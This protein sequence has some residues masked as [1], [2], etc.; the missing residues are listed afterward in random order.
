MLLRYCFSVLEQ[1][2]QQ[3]QEDHK[4]IKN[5][6][7]NKND[8]NIIPPATSSKEE[9]FL[10][11]STTI[12]HVNSSSS[13]NNNDNKSIV[14]NATSSSNN[15]EEEEEEEGSKEN[16]SSPLSAAAIAAAT[17]TT[18]TAHQLPTAILHIGPHKTGSSS[19]QTLTKRFMNELK[20]DNYEMPWAAVRKE[21]QTKSGPT[22]HLFLQSALCPS[23]ISL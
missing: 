9:I 12:N 5:V 23:C 4:E 6:N 7:I 21:I 8:K 3:W 19:I 2:G 1:Y 22:S 11:N 14:T 18:T 10:L 20:M 15:I 13:N 17:T 16:I